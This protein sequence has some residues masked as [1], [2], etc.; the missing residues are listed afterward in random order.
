MPNV[1]MKETTTTSSCPF[2]KEVVMLYCDACSV[3][4]M[5][6]LDHLVSTRPCLAE[7]H[8]QCPLFQDALRRASFGAELSNGPGNRGESGGTG[9]EA[10]P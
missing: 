1:V 10:P 4:K 9:K 7:T 8:D 6:P 2:L 5:L 3:R